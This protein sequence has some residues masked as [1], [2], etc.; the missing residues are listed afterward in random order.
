MPTGAAQYSSKTVEWATP[1]D[2]YDRLNA[3]FNFTLDACAS[4]ENAK[5]ERYYTKAENGLVQSWQAERVFCNPPY[6]RDLGRWVAKA[7]AEVYQRYCPLAVLLLPAR[8]DVEWFHRYVYNKAE[9]RF[10][11]GRLKYGGSVHNA[12]FPSMVVIYENPYSRRKT[13]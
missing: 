4:A 7:F 5:C 1:Q 2:L 8:T 13:K 6:G 10:I 11:E 3:E 9:I 12:P